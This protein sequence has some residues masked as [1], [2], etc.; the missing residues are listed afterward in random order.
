M[1]PDSLWWHTETSWLGF[2]FVRSPDIPGVEELHQF[3]NSASGM[4]RWASLSW[5]PMP[6]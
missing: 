2:R 6:A 1:Q 3:W 5:P 4:T